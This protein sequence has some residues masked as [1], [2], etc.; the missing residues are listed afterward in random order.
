MSEYLGRQIPAHILLA[1]GTVGI[2]WGDPVSAERERE[3]EHMRRL[4]LGECDA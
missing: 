3:L 4:C 1:G 2:R